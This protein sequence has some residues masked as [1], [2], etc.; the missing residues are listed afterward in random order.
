[1]AQKNEAEKMFNE[2]KRAR[3]N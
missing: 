3:H 2:K 1:M